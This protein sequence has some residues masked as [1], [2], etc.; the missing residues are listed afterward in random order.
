V[1][2]ERNKLKDSSTGVI[3]SYND[4]QFHSS[5]ATNCHL[6]KQWGFCDIFRWVSKTVRTLW[7]AAAVRS[8]LWRHYDDDRVASRH[9]MVFFFFG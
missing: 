1:N 7:Q 5:R 6:Q 9:R 4:S 8:L 2:G 3:F